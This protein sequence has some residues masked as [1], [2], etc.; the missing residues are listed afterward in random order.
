[1]DEKKPRLNWGLKSRHV[2][3]ITIMSIYPWNEVTANSS[4]FVQVFSGIGVVGAAGILNFVVL[5]SATD[6]YIFSTS[7][8]LYCSHL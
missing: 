1:M 6:S 8:S 3:M 7:R 5:T 2:T 4:P